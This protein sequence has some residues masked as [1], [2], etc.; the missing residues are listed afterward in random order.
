MLALVL[1]NA[2]QEA[3]SSDIEKVWLLPPMGAFGGIPATKD[4][5]P[6]LYTAET[7]KQ[8]YSRF[9][10]VEVASVIRLSLFLLVVTNYF[11][12]VS[13]MPHTTPI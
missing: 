1:C 11:L 7:T 12:S 2:A 4:N 10:S 3:Y 6:W 9:P 5:K 13:C 8:Q